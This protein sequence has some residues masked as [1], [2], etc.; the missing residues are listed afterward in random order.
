V[1][2]RLQALAERSRSQQCKAGYKR[3]LSEA[4]ANSAKQAAS[5]G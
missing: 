1:H 2:S 4:E 3:W 5:V